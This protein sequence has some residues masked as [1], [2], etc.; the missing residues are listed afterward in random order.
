MFGPQSLARPSEAPPLGVR[1]FAKLAGLLHGLLLPVPF[2]HFNSKPTWSLNVKGISMRFN[3][4]SDLIAII[5]QPLVNEINFFSTILRETNM[6]C[7]W[8][9]NIF[10]FHQSQDKLI[11]I[12]HNR[13]SFSLVTTSHIKICF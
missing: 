5:F 9:L 2:N 11:F 1:M 6:K 4:R 12:I 7:L 8:I 3:R 10:S 13:K